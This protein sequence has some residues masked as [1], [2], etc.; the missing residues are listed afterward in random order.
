MEAP[1]MMSTSKWALLLHSAAAVLLA[2]ILAVL[3]LDAAQAQTIALPTPVS[4]T[5]QPRLAPTATP[6]AAPAAAEEQRRT[7]VV[8]GEGQVIVQPNLA[9]FDIGV[10]TLEPAIAEAVANNAATLEQVLASLSANGVSEADL[11]T[12]SYN[13]YPERDY[14]RGGLAP[15]IGYRVT[16]MVQVTVRDLGQ[17]GALLEAA[18][19][20]GAN[21][22]YGVSFAVDPEARQAAEREARAQATAVLR[23]HA[24][25]LAT[26][27]GAELGELITVS[28]VV[29]TGGLGG[30][31]YGEGGG[32]AGGPVIEPG[33]LTVVVRLQ[34]TFAIAG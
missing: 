20:A 30:Y 21:Q 5:M 19:E 29:G 17:T 23:G 7:I 10:E 15:I 28:E 27:Y 33:G 6:A 24:E 18:T 26:L 8:A 13:I 2:A 4:S 14:E 12:A 31:A 3:L 34:A 1:T 32:G 11:R 16:N 9:Q 22:I 25:E